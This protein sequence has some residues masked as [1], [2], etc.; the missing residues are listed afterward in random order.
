MW[1]TCSMVDKVKLFLIDTS[2]LVTAILVGLVISFITTICVAIA[3]ILEGCRLLGEK[4]DTIGVVG[5][6]NLLYTV[7]AGYMILVMAGY[8]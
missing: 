7:L 6:T 3:G 2:I 8:A 1:T 4:I 5:V